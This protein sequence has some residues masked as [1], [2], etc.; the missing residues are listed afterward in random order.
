MKIFKRQDSTKIGINKRSNNHPIFQN[1]RRTNTN[2][3]VNH[4]NNKKN[5]NN[6]PPVINRLNSLDFVNK[7]S[8]LVEN[9][10]SEL[11]SVK[12]EIKRKNSAINKLLKC[13]SKESNSSNQNDNN[14]SGGIENI[15]KISLNSCSAYANQRAI[16]SK[17][18]LIRPYL[19]SLS[20]Y[21]LH[22]QQQQ[23]FHNIYSGQYANFFS[24]MES[25]D[26]KMIMTSGD[27]EDEG[28]LSG[29]KQ[30]QLE[31]LFKSNIPRNRSKMKRTKNVSGKNLV[32]INRREFT[33]GE[34]NVF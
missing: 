28:I 10:G 18:A 24:E 34:S 19:S 12:S 14:E 22:G 5:G 16:S 13:H 11:G 25:L 20:N 17:K 31:Y 21:S 9:R 1:Q 33:K 2:N 30:K 32:C 26:E 8:H 6:S 3:L 29:I 27:V 15:K 23:L 7:N 4:V